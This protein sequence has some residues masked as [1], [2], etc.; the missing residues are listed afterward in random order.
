[1]PS[2]DL[3]IRCEGISKKFCRELKRTMYYG[4]KDS[5]R[6]VLGRGALTDRLRKKEFWALDDISFE[7]KRGECLGV[8]GGNGAGKST[9]LKLL[10]GIIRPDKGRVS[11][12]GRV[13]ALIQI[14]AGF[15]PQLTGRENIYVNGEILGMSKS[16]IQ[17]HF[18]SIVD[19]A[20]IG[21]FLD[22]PVK[23]Y[24]SGM[25]V[26]LGFAVAIHMQPDILLVDE[27]LA[28]GDVGFRSKCYNA[29]YDLSRSCAIILVS[30]SM[31]HIH[32]NC[33]SVMLLEKGKKRI[34]SNATHEA[35]SQYYQS[36]NSKDSKRIQLADDVVV[37]NLTINGEMDPQSVSIGFPGNLTIELD[38]VF[39]A[40]HQNIE[41]G[42]TILSLGH[43]IVAGSN[44]YIQKHVIENTGQMVHCRIAL[45]NLR[46]GSEHKKLSI[47]IRDEDRNSILYWGHSICEIRSELDNFCPYPV[48]FPAEF[49]FS[50]S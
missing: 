42:I 12:R 28:V 39:P 24:S 32:R 21:D 34:L 50:A 16:Y 18:D 31:N 11:I 29:M 35:I 37:K 47:L 4:I 44:S 20:D 13:G 46:L 49:E 36:C 1:M 3:L 38:A 19:F 25:H 33:T 6:R 22:T 10:N 27:I 41:V 5:V 15:H 2:D 40:K 14:G 9:L 23:F 48:F 45:K 43:D 26:R 7:L 30:H 8:I 17:K